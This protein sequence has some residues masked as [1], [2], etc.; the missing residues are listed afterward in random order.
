ME[1]ENKKEETEGPPQVNS[2]SN[3][4]PE[5]PLLK[6]LFRPVVIVGALGYF[7]DLY[8]MTL[9]MNVRE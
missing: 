2:R 7:V 4:E 8:D 6:D 1:E 9:F 5:L 3:A